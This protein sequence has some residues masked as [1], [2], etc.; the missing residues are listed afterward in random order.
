MGI[1]KRYL[2][3]VIIGSRVARQIEA[4]SH[5]IAKLFC[6]AITENLVDI[7]LS[8]IPDEDIELVAQSLNEVD[9]CVSMN[10]F[11]LDEIW[12]EI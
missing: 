11:V 5:H 7:Y 3:G 12:V 8:C 6:S 4:D 2:S 1:E 9:L 10:K